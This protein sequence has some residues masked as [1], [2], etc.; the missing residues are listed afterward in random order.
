MFGR[1]Y[2]SPVLSTPATRTRPATEAAS[3]DATWQVINSLR[4]LAM[5]AVEQSQSGHPGTPMALA[6]AAI[7]L[8]EQCL[9]FDPAAPAWPDRDR[10]VLSCG[11]ASMLLYGLLHLSGY[12]LTLEDLRQFRQWGS[13]TPGH[14]ERGHTVG[15]ET[16]TGPLGQGVGNAVGMAIAERV[17]RERFNRPGHEVIDH[18][19]WGFVS[20]G[21]L[22]EGVASEAAS[23]AGHLGLGRLTLIFDDNH[24]TID[25]D[26]ALSFTEDVGRRFEA[27]GW[28]VLRVADGN[29][30]AAIAAALA[31]ARAEAARPTLVVLRT[32][33]GDPAPTK[34]NTSAAHGAP[35]GK[36][37]V[38]KTKAILGWPETPFHVA[39]ETVAWRDAARRRGA[40]AH[41]DWSARFAAYRAAHPALAA[42]L[43]QWLSGALPA[44]WDDG[45]PGF[46]PADGQLATRQA[47]A[48]VLNALAAK[49]PNLMGGSAD[50]AES[51]GTDIKG[52]GSFSATGT[53]RNVHWG[54]R[55]HG[56]GACLNGMAAHGG[57]RPF[58]STFLIF[59][60]YCK[61]SIR[62]A[63]L[64]QLPVV[65]I[66]THD[67]IGLGEDGPTHQPIEQLAM[68]RSTPNVTVIRPADA[69]ETVEAWKA[70]V[71]RA[72]GPTVLVLSR[73]KLPILDRTRYA[74]A[75]G[76]ARGGY[77]LLDAPGGT[78]AAIVMAT[79]AEVHLAL[80]A[81]E[82]LQ[83][84]GVAAR[85][86]SLP[87]WEL[88][89]AQPAAYREAVLPAAVRAR[90]A[91]EAATSFGWHRWVGERGE[92]VGIDH[93]G[94]SAPADRLFKEFGFTAD[95]IV[96]A[97]TRV[98]S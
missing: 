73:Q 20:D 60:D 29:D 21:D 28:H 83:A 81:V 7:V 67:S 57:I 77:V 23:L 96:A 74:P 91:V 80:A 36:D 47:S 35:L 54:V 26:T 1:P 45:L 63:G 56:M 27:Y 49:L 10:F 51:T 70:A 59:T 92:V 6:P 38:A 42:E 9:R 75:E 16:T 71:R 76:A 68:L 64:M 46:T 12:E 24:I 65:Y 19:V 14:P 43:E 98:L 61:P 15:V 5:D 18:R 88:F 94:A 72:D 41:A 50:L 32:K 30:L 37:E 8:W 31:A 52:G 84:S 40:A 78:P 33:I 13:K 55:E 85:L 89:A 4:V 58:G 48:K 53:G 34:G 44:G 17:L 93:F 39:P 95:G 2:R 87:S 62:L 79:G 97:V 69:N 3:S 82:R 25:G 66:G 90:V 22:M 86:V 11:H